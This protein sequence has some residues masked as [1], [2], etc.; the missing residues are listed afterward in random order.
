[1]NRFECCIRDA[2]CRQLNAKLSNVVAVIVVKLCRKTIKRE[3]RD[4]ILGFVFTDYAQQQY[5]YISCVECLLLD[6]SQTAVLTTHHIFACHRASISIS[7]Q[8]TNE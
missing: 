8:T 2:N 6:S 1:M 4:K 3:A 7:Q 5:F